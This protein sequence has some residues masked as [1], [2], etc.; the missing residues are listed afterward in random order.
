MLSSNRTAVICSGAVVFAPDRPSGTATAS[1]D[2]DYPFVS[3]QIADSIAQISGLLQSRGTSYQVVASTSASLPDLREHPIILLGGYNNPW[4]Q[5]LTTP[6]RFHFTP[7]PNYSIVDRD[8]PA[9]VWRR[10]SSQSY[11][12]SDDY[13]LVARFRDSS[14]NSNVLVL[15]GLGRNGTEGAMQFVTSPH[16]MQDLQSKLGG[17]LSTRNFEV[18]LRSGVID[19]KTGAPSIEA[20]FTW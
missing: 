9:V 2:T 13:A 4:T 7:E 8:Q 12:A 6:L 10:N 11:S 20:V 19:A 17:D 1:R 18:I 14:T 5:R 15:A 16:Y 3:M